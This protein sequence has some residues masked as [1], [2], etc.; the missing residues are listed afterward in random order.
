MTSNLIV[1]KIG[2]SSLT[3]HS[4]KLDIVNIRRIARQVS[5]LIF[6]QK[7]VI[8]VSSGAIVS[9][10]GRLGFKEKPRAIA[11]KQAAAA[12]GQSL[13]MRQYE[14]AFE[15]H[16]VPVGQILLTYDVFTD[17][18]KKQNAYNTI[19]TLL[20]H[21]A[22][23]IVNENDTVAIDEIKV[24]DN[25]NLSAMVAVLMKADLL[26]NLTDVDGF[27]LKSE[28]GT[29]FKVD[30]IEKINKKIEEAATLSDKKHGTGGMITKLQAARLCESAGISMVIAHGKKEDISKIAAGE[31]IGTR[32]I[33]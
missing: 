26:I 12:V 20:K 24:G 15:R 22:V 28:D 2:S 33:F 6:H 16:N 3:D 25:D 29:V 19:H 23:P 18:I 11:E 4:G 17:E 9:G 10:S 13:L 7:H 5:A 32:F 27:Y 30:E 1:L 14:K 8:I 31:K 21:R